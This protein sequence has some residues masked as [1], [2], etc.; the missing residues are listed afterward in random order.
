ALRNGS[1][2]PE[3]SPKLNAFTLKKPTLLAIYMNSETGPG[4]AHPA[5]LCGYFDMAFFKADEV[6]N[7]FNE[8]RA[9]FFDFGPSARLF[10]SLDLGAGAGVVTI[11]SRNSNGNNFETNRATLVP[12]RAV[13]R[14]LLVFV[15]DHRR[16]RWMG[17]VGIF[18]KETYIS[19]KFNGADFGDA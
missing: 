2:A 16:Q 1:I 10:D 12:I 17:V 7:G 18:F 9:H 11:H 3:D 8:V 4:H 15:P 19:G 13:L 6:P 14:P 5:L